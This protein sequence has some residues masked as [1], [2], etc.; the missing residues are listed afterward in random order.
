M[1]A[2]TDLP[3]IFENGVTLL[4][5]R[6]PNV[7]R[8]VITNILL[9]KIA[10]MITSKR[11]KY[12]ELRKIGLPNHYAIVFMPSGYGKDKMSNELDTYV[13][14]DWRLWF[15]NKVNDYKNAKIEAIKRQAEI[16][17]TDEKQARQKKKFINEEVA[18]IRDLPIEISKGTP[19]GLF[20]DAKSFKD[21]EFGSITV[22]YGE[23][24]LMLKNAR[25]ED[26]LILQA[27]FELYDGKLSSKSIKSENNQ[28]EITDL[29]CNVLFYSDPTLF[30][31][32]LKKVFNDMMQTGLGRRAV[33]SYLPEQ[34]LNIEVDP[35]K[36]YQR[37]KEFAHDA[38]LIGRKL[39]SI[40]LN[41]EMNT[42]FT[43]A[44]DTY[45]TVF[46]PYKI[47]LTEEANKT[48]NSLLKRE[49]LSRELKALKVSCL[50]AVLNHTKEHFIYQEDMKQAISTVDMLGEDFKYF[51]KIRPA[52]KDIYDRV[53][54][55]FKENI[56]K[57]YS[58]TDLKRKYYK[59]FG[60]GRK[61]FNK[62]FEEIMNYVAE[63]ATD[64]GFLFNV[65]DIQPTGKKY[66]LVEIPSK[67]LNENIKSLTQLIS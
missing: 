59:N 24:G 66:S 29:P 14:K 61:A 41:L 25:P 67:E 47:R 26:Y 38:E 30:A 53:F 58:M 20:A 64:K 49:I 63:I 40:F 6:Y 65:K 54:E 4:K 50:F 48:E 22:K 36:A 62:D 57:E 56:G 39:F 1:T 19:E 43:L 18:K 55:F 13:F 44:E 3:E 32:E 45:K 12:N 5:S 7:S 10:Q 33:I 42:E 28:S 37:D 34:N 31:D 46:Y 21:A 17:F 51:I 23:F 2:N 27:L 8:N 35:E 16:E 52:Y 11:V 60:C 9:T 15:Y